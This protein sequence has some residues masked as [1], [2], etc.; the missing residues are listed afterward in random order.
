[1]KL[2]I[3]TLAFVKYS[4]KKHRGTA[5]QRGRTE[6]DVWYLPGASKGV[7]TFFLEFEINL[8]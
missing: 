8:K 7:P 4:K 2:F 5:G 3:I 1:M 6:K